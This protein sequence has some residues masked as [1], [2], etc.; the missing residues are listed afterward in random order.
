MANKFDWKS[1][2]KQFL[3]EGFD[4]E[5]KNKNHESYF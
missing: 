1:I 3:I 5:A 2:E 4:W